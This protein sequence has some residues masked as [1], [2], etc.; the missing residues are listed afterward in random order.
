MAT[1]Y[2]QVERIAFRE[3]LILSLLLCILTVALV[4]FKSLE[5]LDMV[6]YDRYMQLNSREARDDILIVAIDDYSLSELG[7]WPWPRQRHAELL[8]HINA[9]T[10][11]AIGMDIL[12][13]EAE[14]PQAGNQIN[15][16][17]L[18]ADAIAQSNKVVLP[19]VS[20]NSGKGLV[21]ARPFPCWQMRHGRSAT[22][23]SNSTKTAWHAV[24][25]CVKDQEAN[26]GLTLHLR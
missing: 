3:W 16:D 5:R 8:K 4:N 17:Q 13:T 6:A 14:Y 10:P 15:G 23:I 12:L 24:S 1:R 11:A 26:G 7:K 25:F 20:Q 18:L 19:L 21:A 22:S 2:I 9:A